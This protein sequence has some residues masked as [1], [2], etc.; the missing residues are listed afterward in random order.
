MKR[1]NSSMQYKTNSSNI[2]QYLLKLH[3][4]MMWNAIS[5]IRLSEQ[6]VYVHT[7]AP[8]WILPRGKEGIAG[9][10]RIR[11]VCRIEVI[12]KERCG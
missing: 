10:R 2:R 11:R 6:W 7:H 8:P 4:C 3:S 12:I 9:Q 5:P 1:D